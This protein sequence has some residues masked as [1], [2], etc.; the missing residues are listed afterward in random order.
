MTRL[1]EAWRSFWVATWLG[2]QVEANWTDPWIFIVYALLKPL[3]RAVILVF[4]YGV[5]TGAAFEQP[6]FP[7][8]YLGNTFYSYVYA[9]MTGVSWAIID[10]REHYKTLKYL[11]VAPLRMP[12]YLLGRGVARFLTNTASVLV[13]LGAGVA[14]LKLPLD[15]AQINWGMAL[16]GLLVGVLMLAMMGLLLAAVS[17]LMVH[18]SWGVVEGVAGALFLFSGAVFPLEI[19]PAW[20]RPVGY[21]MPVTYWLEVMRRALLG[22]P[23]EA[24]PVLSAMSDGQL[25][26]IMLALSAFFAMVAWGAFRVCDHLA[27][28]RG[29]IDW[30]TNY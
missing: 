21:V 9:I 16:A 3:A 7:Y 28:E 26:A 30:T 24:S 13:M 25:F 14:F 2:W 11:Y 20:L 29:L 18:H 22:R 23:L 12:V 6:F 17:L 4:M 10:D 5:I 8:L 27:R 1:R 19:L 15:V